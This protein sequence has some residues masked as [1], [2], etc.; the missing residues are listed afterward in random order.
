MIP[1][2][3]QKSREKK[4]AILKHSYDVLHLLLASVSQHVTYSI[5]HYRYSVLGNH[6]VESPVKIAMKK[7]IRRVEWRTAEH[8]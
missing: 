5:A 2:F 4:K 8:S 3:S 1:T 6:R 7:K